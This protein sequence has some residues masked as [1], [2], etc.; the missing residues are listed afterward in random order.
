MKTS[1]AIVPFIDLVSARASNPVVGV[2]VSS[3][4]FSESAA[5]ASGGFFADM[6]SSDFHRLRTIA[7]EE[8][9][10]SKQMFGSIKDLEDNL[11][12]YYWQKNFE[13]VI[14]CQFPRRLGARGDG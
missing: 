1:A 11:D 2:P 4:G 10:N 14:S 8:N 5:L 13:P 9:I 12:K 7:C 3:D 6:P